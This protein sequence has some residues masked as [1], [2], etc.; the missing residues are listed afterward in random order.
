MHYILGL[1]NP[2]EEYANTRHNTGRLTLGSF[3]KKNDFPELVPNKKMKALVGEG[4]AGKEKV[5]VVFPETYMNKSGKSVASVITSVK[6]AHDLVVVYD[7]LDLALGNIKISYNRG[8]GGHR[9]LE[10]IMKAIKT[11]EFVRIRVGISPQTPSGKLKKPKGDKDV[12]RWILGDYKPKEI[13]ILK[14]V[15]KTVADA[16]EMIVK[17]GH[18]LAMGEFNT[19]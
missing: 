18:E 13:E 8:S 19:K 10:S 15:G 12:E 7:D 11:G 3:L 17:D 4:K 14:K 6:K 2:G 1:G 5:T 9:G 16:V